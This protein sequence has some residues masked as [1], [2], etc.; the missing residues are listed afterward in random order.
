MVSVESWKH[1]AHSCY[2]GWYR[3][4]TGAHDSVS[5]RSETCCSSPG[6]FWRPF[7]WVRSCRC[8]SVGRRSAL[9]TW[10]MLVWRRRCCRASWTMCCCCSFTRPCLAPAKV[11]TPTLMEE[12][13]SVNIWQV[14]WEKEF[15]FPLDLSTDDQNIIQILKTKWWKYLI[16]GVADVEANYTVV[17]AYQFTSL[18]SIQVMFVFMI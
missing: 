11:R 2:L 16:M 15:S 5:H 14:M 10:P 3:A 18:T 9:S 8:S 6:I 4:W 13:M 7:W 12:Y 17:K 1:S